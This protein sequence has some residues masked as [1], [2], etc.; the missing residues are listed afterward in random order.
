MRLNHDAAKPA[1]WKGEIDTLL[2][3]E[4]RPPTTAMQR[5]RSPAVERGIDADGQKQAVT[6]DC[7][8]VRQVR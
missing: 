6:G 4:P 8:P 7:Y 1:E 3:F 5:E 2:L